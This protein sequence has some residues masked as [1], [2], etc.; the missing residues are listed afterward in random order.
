MS[1]SKEKWAAFYKRSGDGA[2]YPTEWV[3]R[4]IAGGKYPTL[5]LDRSA[6]PGSKILDLSCGDGRNIELLLD[7]GF[8]VHGT[9]ISLSQVELL[10]EK[11]ERLGWPV[12]FSV[13]NNA[14]LPFEDEAFDYI[15]A[16]S[17]MYYLDVGVEWETVL[18][19][20]SRVLKPGGLLFANFPDRENSV[21]LE[22]K[23]KP[24]GTAVIGQDPF[25][26]RNGIRFMTAQSV[27]DVQNRMGSGFLVQSAGHQANDYYGLMVS[28]YIFVA[29]KC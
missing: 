5:S 3:V 21:L 10:A 27:E 29:K 26:L 28:G 1:D 7:L 18:A 19:E 13:G 11:G 20:V 25:N 8:E 17:S 15:L 6:F 12:H 23:F 9:E 22:A 4:T 14:S 24:D 2:R 16:C